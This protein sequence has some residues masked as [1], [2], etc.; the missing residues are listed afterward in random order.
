VSNPHETCILSKS[1]ALLLQM[2]P[3]ALSLP[4][5]N[6]HGDSAW[7]NKQT[8]Y[9]RNRDAVHITSKIARAWSKPPPSRNCATSVSERVRM[10]LSPDGTA[11]RD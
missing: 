10:G 8:I 1:S 6:M 2:D 11:L 4:V 3:P 7:P 9:V 5:S